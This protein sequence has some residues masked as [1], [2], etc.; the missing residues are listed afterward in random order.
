MY[1]KHPDLIVPNDNMTIWRYLDFTKFVS[2][3]DKQALFFCRADKMDD[4]FEGSHPKAELPI[5][6]KN[7]ESVFLKDV[8]EAF[9]LIREFTAVNCWHINRYE[10]FAMWKLYL[11]SSEGIAIRSTFRRLR[12]SLKDKQHDIYIGKVQYIDYEKDIFLGLVLSPFVHKRKSFDHEKELRAIIQEMPKPGL[13]SEDKRPFENGLYVP[14]DLDLLINEIYL[15]PTSPPWIKELVESVSMK[16][17]LKKK[18]RQ[19][20]LDEPPIY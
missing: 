5:R 8:S 11:K 20:E 3:L 15:A 6:T 1:K 7:L 18:V 12:D 9:R 13:Y 4:K 16:Y 10:S 2:L 19:S 14:V 17:G